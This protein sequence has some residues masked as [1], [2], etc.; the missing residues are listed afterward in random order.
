MDLLYNQRLFSGWGPRR[1]LH[2]ARFRWANKTVRQLGYSQLR[3]IEIGC[4]DGHL[5]DY[6]P[7]KVERYV[8]LDAG[9]EGGLQ[10]GQRRFAGRPNYELVLADDPYK[11]RDFQAERFNLGA[12]LETLEHVPPD[13]VDAYL[14][15]LSLVI[16]GHLLI[17]VPNE[18]GFAFLMKWL[19]KKL[20]LGGTQPYDASEILAATLGRMEQ[21]TRDDH[22]GF[23]Y[24]A[25]VEQV[26]RYFEIVRVDSVPLNFLPKPLSMTI[27]ILAKSKA[28]K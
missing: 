12:A 10:E 26:R 8:G 17:T 11:I 3:V 4:F 6:L 20:F 18:K 1:Y 23:D 9:W 16:D 15:E 14:E 13:L 19:I 2:T 7:G 24:S 22:K 28:R 27:C 25:L 5:L 21:V